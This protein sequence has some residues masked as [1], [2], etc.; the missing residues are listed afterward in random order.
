MVNAVAGSFRIQTKKIGLLISL[1]ALGLV[2]FGCTGAPAYQE[3]SGVVGQGGSLYFGTMDGRVFAINPVARSQNA[4]FPGEG[5]WVFAKFPAVATPGSI[6]GPA[7]AP[8]GPRLSVYTTPAVA[9]DLVCVGTY[10]ASGGKV[11]AI[12][13]LAPGY[14]DNVPLRSKGEWTYPGDV[15][16]IGAIVGSPVVANDTLYVGSSDGRLYA[17]NAVYGELRWDPVDTRGKIWTAPAVEGGIVYVGNYAKRLNAIKDGKELWHNEYASVIASPPVVSEGVIYFGTFDHYLYA[18]NSTDGSEKWRF[19]GD[20]W[21]WASPVIQNGVV[22][23]GCLDHKVY[24][25][26]AG[27]GEEMW[28]FT[29]DDQIV[30][31]PVLVEGFLVVASESGTVYMLQTDSG[32]PK[33]DAVSV[34]GPVIAPLYSEG[35]MI[36][37]HSS[38]RYIYCIDALS[39]KKVWEFSY[40]NIK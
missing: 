14:T 5:E 10:T 16:S 33:Y 36:Y 25:I 32:K 4:A 39:G 27:S 38:N 1:I 28:Q 9:G 3:W 11:V 17:L 29:A 23:A 2:V 35:S 37:V 24:A 22:F 30:A 31:T 12:N 18:T 40:S 26:D 7:C 13:R 8:A 20:S 21:F 6:C 15:K 34:G 19:K